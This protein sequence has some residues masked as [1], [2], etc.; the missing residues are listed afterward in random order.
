MTCDVYKPDGRCGAGP[1]KVIAFGIRACEDCLRVPAFVEQ[2]NAQIHQHYLRAIGA[3]ET[4]KR[5]AHRLSFW[6]KC[7]R[8]IDLMNP[9]PPFRSGPVFKPYYGGGPAKAEVQ[10][11]G[12]IHRWPPPGDPNPGTDG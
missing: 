10:A 2:I 9:F 5:A 1:A 7:F 11:R 4:P 3:T 6:D 8:L 12:I